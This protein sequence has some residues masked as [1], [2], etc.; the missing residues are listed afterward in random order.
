[1]RPASCIRIHWRELSG[2]AAL[3]ADGLILGLAFLI[4]FAVSPAAPVFQSGASLFLLCTGAFLLAAAATGLTRI[5]VHTSLRLHAALAVRSYLWG[6]AAIAGFLFLAGASVE[7]RGFLGWYLLAVP[8]CYIGVWAALR[9]VLARL[10]ARV[11]GSWR[12]L[13]TGEV[14]DIRRALS[15]LQSSP[16][17]GYNVVRVLE[18]AGPED[19]DT[20]RSA[21]AFPGAVEHLLIAA[22][23]R[24]GGVDAVLDVRPP[25]GVGITLLSRDTDELFARARIDDPAGAPLVPP[26]AG[27]LA[28]PRAVLKR[29][30]DIGGALLLL[31][32]AAPL[33]LMI[34]AATAI[35]TRGPVIFRQRRALA[36]D[37][38]AF[39]VYKF[40]SMIHD[41]ARNGGDHRARN[42]AD[43]ALFKIRNDPR[44]T[45]VGKLLRRHS[46]DELPQLINV[47]RGEMSLVGPRPLPVEDLALLGPGGRTDLW[48]RRRAG[49]RPGMTG[50]WQVSGRSDLA[51]QDMVLLDLYYAQHQSVL[52]DLEILFRTLPV[53]FFGRGAY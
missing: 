1:M 20:L 38:P 42:E 8:L 25:P 15:R 40:R 36:G 22:P 49:A 11:Y 26:A 24:N 7:L 50:L 53:V 5:V 32:L 48:A 21:L 45:R 3:L 44:R 17:L 18:W 4:A 6:S 33:M 28:R 19:S 16:E 14:A 12:T 37:L 10:R 27:L 30:F 13:V 51:F 35:E 52:F 41:P 2:T 23:H 31:T 47:L 39:D 34:A 46:L 29:A 43:G 9:A